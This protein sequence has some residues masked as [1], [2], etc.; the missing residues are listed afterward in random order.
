MAVLARGHRQVDGF[1]R[2]GRSVAMVAT[3]ELAFG[4][5]VPASYVEFVDEMLSSTPF[6]V[7]A[8]FFSNFAAL[9][10]FETVKALVGGADER[11]SAA[12]PTRSPRS[13]TAAS[14]TPTSPARTCSSA[15]G[16]GHLVIM[17]RHDEV[18]AELDHLLA[19]AGDLADRR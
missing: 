5:D 7:V 16:A 4:D 19:A 18:N 13:V 15:Q 11:S 3:D 8:E 2:L 12:R 17:E 14:C 9:D 1:R 6:E 10:K